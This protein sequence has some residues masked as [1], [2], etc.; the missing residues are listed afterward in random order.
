MPP[1]SHL[2]KVTELLALSADSSSGRSAPVSL[3]SYNRTDR[4]FLF[5]RNLCCLR[6][7]PISHQLEIVFSGHR[8]ILVAL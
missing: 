3:P 1:E 4:F 8:I 7:F 2:L 5:A 6:L